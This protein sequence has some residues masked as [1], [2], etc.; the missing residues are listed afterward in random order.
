MRT[1]SYVYVPARLVFPPP[2]ADGF[3]WERVGDDGTEF[4]TLVSGVGVAVEGCQGDH[5]KGSR[6][7]TGKK[8]KT[9]KN[10]ALLA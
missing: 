5:R 10:P 9:G 8:A 3:E 6:D 1:K 2:P 7:Q 4:R